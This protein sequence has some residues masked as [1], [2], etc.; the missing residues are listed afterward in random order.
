M[1]HNV[2]SLNEEVHIINKNGAYCLQ[3]IWLLGLKLGQKI[4]IFDSLSLNCLERRIGEDSA[5]K[6]L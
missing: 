2:L 3:M 4:I 5:I 6:K 1:L